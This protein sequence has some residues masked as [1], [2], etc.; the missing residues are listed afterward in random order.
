MFFCC[1]AILYEFQC[2]CADHVTEER[3]KPFRASLCAPFSLVFKGHLLPAATACCCR[4]AMGSLHTPASSPFTSELPIFAKLL[5]GR[6]SPGPFGIHPADIQSVVK[7]GQRTQAPNDPR[8]GSARWRYT[9]RGIT[10]VTDDA[11]TRV[12]T[13]YLPGDVV[14]PTAVPTTEHMLFNARTKDSLTRDRTLCTS[15]AVIVVDDSEAMAVRD[16]RGFKSRSMAALGMLAIEFVAKERLS[17]GM[18]ETDVATVIF[19][20]D[21]PRVAIEVEPVG[22]VLYNKLFEAFSGQTPKGSANFLPALDMAETYVRWL[23][24]PGCALSLFFLSPGRPSDA[25][26]PIVHRVKAMAK[27]FGSQLFVFT[28][29]FAPESHDFSVL[30]AMAKVAEDAGATG[31]FR[32]AE[33][34]PDVLGKTVDHNKK[35]S[36]CSLTMTRSMLTAAGAQDFRPRE[37]RL[38]EMEAAGSQWDQACSSWEM[39]D[40]W[41]VYTENVKRLA[42]S[43]VAERRGREPWISVGME[44][45]ANCIAIRRKALGEGAERLV[46]GMQVWWSCCRHV[47]LCMSSCTHV[48]CCGCRVSPPTRM[49]C[50]VFYI[51]MPRLILE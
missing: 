27:E 4:N 45:T 10:C 2:V 33:S 50:F 6:E 51:L 9:F 46:F 28:L 47:S 29:G 34:F 14:I 39:G 38:V 15:H 49:N 18:C 37:L 21:R 26:Q 25:D 8:T 24:H 48:A 41:M 42:Y 3:H 7:R 30:E 16:L 31:C 19:M 13:A 43:P 12:I 35:D 5:R 40:G 22:L 20:A 17:G 44:S 11:S 23:L 32:Q 36:I 1:C